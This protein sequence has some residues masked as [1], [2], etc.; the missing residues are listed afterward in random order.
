MHFKGSG[1][2]PNIQILFGPLGRGPVGPAVEHQGVFDLIPELPAFFIP[3][4]VVKDRFQRFQAGIPHIGALVP[5]EPFTVI[6]GGQVKQ[7]VVMGLW[8]LGVRRQSLLVP[9][10]PGQI[11]QSAGLGVKPAQQ[12]PH[13]PGQ[14]FKR[15]VFPLPFMDQSQGILDL[16][17]TVRVKPISAAQLQNGDSQPDRPL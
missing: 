15:L 14:M 1:S 9:A 3:P 12:H 6:Q 13:G 11:H 2:D 4:F 16:Q 7:A 10:L 8:R 17:H 5:I